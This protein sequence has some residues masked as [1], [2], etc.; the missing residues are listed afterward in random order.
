MAVA[1]DRIGIERVLAGVEHDERVHFEA[2][3]DEVAGFR[4]SRDEG[5]T[6]LL[7]GD[8]LAEEIEVRDEVLFAEAP[9]GEFDEETIVAVAVPVVAGLLI[10][11]RAVFREHAGGVRVAADGI[12]PADG[13]R[14]DRGEQAAHVGVQAIGR[15]QIEDVL[16]LERVRHVVALG[17]FERVVEQHADV[18]ATVDV[19]EAEAF[20]ARNDGGPHAG[21]VECFF[22][23]G[24]HARDCP[25]VERRDEVG[26]EGELGGLHALAGD[27]FVG[28][29]AQGAGGALHEDDFENVFVLQQDVLRGNDFGDVVAEDPREV[30]E[31][32][33]FGLVVN[34]GE[35]PG[36]DFGA[37]FPQ[38]LG[39]VLVDHF[40][41][42]LRPAVETPL[43]DEALEG[44]EGV[45]R[46]RDGHAPQSVVGPNGCHS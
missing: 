32:G 24:I 17:A 8:D 30:A 42:R 39:G 12:V 45:F 21:A 31:Q 7:I 29:V 34:Q 43:A 19:G 22:E 5:E 1:I 4:V 26:G 11:V 14:G 37:D 15:A 16:A 6:S 40:R 27:E 46:H 2:E 33:A 3:F 36:H 23:E 28:D 13:I 41:D 38:M 9:F 10:V 25:C 44:Q 35:G 18:R 20:A